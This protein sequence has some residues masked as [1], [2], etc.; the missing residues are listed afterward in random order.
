MWYRGGLSLDAAAAQPANLVNNFFRP[1][2]GNP[3]RD[4]YAVP[5]REAM[6]PEPS[7]F[8]VLPAYGFY[9]RHAA[10]VRF[11]GVEVGFM[12]PDTRPAF[13]LDDVRGA[14]LHGVRAQAAASA[15]TFVLR[16]VEDF[17]ITHSAPL[18]DTY[19]KRATRQSF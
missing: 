13:V 10:N 17:R 1:P 16:D 4:P 11:E 5:E 12:S 18:R 7:L 19:V 9:V 6:Y 2:G 8:G 14:E 3:P 15:P